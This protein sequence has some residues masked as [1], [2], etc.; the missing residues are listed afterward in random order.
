MSDYFNL[1]NYS[2]LTSKVTVAQTWFD[3]GIVWLFG[4]NHEEAILCF[5][6]T[7]EADPDCAMAYW[8]IAYAIG[9]NYNK[10]WEVF[11][12]EEKGP[13]LKRAHEA[14]E[15]G[16]ALGSATPIELDL[17]N[18][19]VSR[20]PDD[21]EIEDYQPFNDGFAVAMKPVYEKYS[22]DL[23]VAFV[24]AE[25]MMNRTPWQLWDYHKGVPNPEA[26]TEEAMKVLED[27]FEARSDA[28]DHPG[29]LHM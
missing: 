11:T 20:Y 25:A 17:L 12:P 3:R 28:W 16:L 2:R 1:G 14:L 4:Y 10:P 27:S 23:D 9:P 24:Y 6:R 8:G 22:E 29:L 15:A 19:L 21:P 13:A 26:S 7:L 18:A 5:E